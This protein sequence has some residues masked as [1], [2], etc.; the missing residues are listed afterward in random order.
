MLKKSKVF[1][2]VLFTVFLLI[3]SS[4]CFGQG[5]G[6][7]SGL[8]GGS[9]KK[10]TTTSTTKPK[11]TTTKKPST[12]TKKPA[13]TAKKTTPVKPKTSANTAQKNNPRQTANRNTRRPTIAKTTP[14]NTIKKTNT[15]V[16]S[17][18]VI[19]VGNN[20]TTTEVYDE[21][22]ETALEDGNEARDMRDYVRAENSYRRAA[23]MTTDDSRAVYGLGNVYSDQQRWDEAE[24][25]YRKAIEIEKDNADAYVALSYVLAQPIPA[26]NL[27]ERY[28]EAEKMARKAIEYDSQNPFAYDQLGI[29]LELRGVINQETETAYRRAIQIEPNFALA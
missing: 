9:T 5:L 7:T 24:K 6:S 21:N 28:A 20:E 18:T 10:T 16:Q 12:T 23:S 15:P 11:A 17:T 13:T 4:V 26:E 2:F 14:K 25:F 22:L 19:T 3:G 8:F 29:A 1:R 27:S